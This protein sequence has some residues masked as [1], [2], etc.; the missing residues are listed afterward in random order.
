MA[1]LRPTTPL[2]TSGVT[3]IRV[4]YCECDPMGVAHHAAFIPWLEI[5]RTEL[6]RVGGITYK[7]LEAAGMFL[8]VASLDI[9][10]RRPGRYDDLLGVSC[11]VS[12]GSRVKLEH[13]YEVRVTERVG[14]D[15]ERLRASGDD[16]LA[17]ARTT[18]VCVGA[19]MGVRALPEWLAAPESARS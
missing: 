13:E 3:P 1:E 7:Q 14:D 17:T 11:R 19:G 2:P 5:A 18:L 16:L 9:R 15:P 8:V 12:G 4:R 6:L 10:Y